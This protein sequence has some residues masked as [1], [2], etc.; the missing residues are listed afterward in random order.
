MPSANARSLPAR[1]GGSRPSGGVRL[2]RRGR[3]SE[4]PASRPP[5]RVLPAGTVFRRRLMLRGRAVTVLS[6]AL[7][8]GS[9]L[10]TVVVDDLVAQGQ[11]QL[12]RVQAQLTAQSAQHRQLQMEVAGMET[13][14]QVVSQAQA[15][16]MVSPGQV[17]DL[18]AVPLS[19]PLP[20]PTT[21]TSTGTTTPSTATA[22]TTP[23][24]ATA[25]TTPSTTPSTATASTTPSQAH[26]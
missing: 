26:P 21:T 19:T 8:V 22:S 18:P 13:P 17:L 25:S 1:A 7:V 16:G 24:T 9:L 14:S 3:P 23:S 2:P 12:A 10:V 15:D 11:V 4:G 5:L 6:V 20:A